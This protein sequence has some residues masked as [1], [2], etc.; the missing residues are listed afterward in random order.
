M[1]SSQEIEASLW[2]D[3][4]DPW[5][6]RCVNPAGGFYQEF[7]A[8]WTRQ[9]GTDRTVVFQS[10]MTWVTATAS[11]LGGT[12]DQ[13]FAGYAAHGV[14]SLVDRFQNPT[15]GAIYWQEGQT[16]E[17]HAYGVSFAIYALAAAARA[18]GSAEA[19]DAAIRAFHWLELHHYDPENGGYYEA[20]TASGMVITESDQDRDDLG[21]PYGQKSQNT[22]LH[23]LEAFTE[24]YREW[25]DPQLKIRLTELLELFMGALYVAPGW[26]YQFTLPDWTPVPLPQGD[27][28]FGH[29]VEAAHLMLD[30][31]DAL[32]KRDDP[33]VM[34]AA[35]SLVDYALQFGFKDGLLYAA[36]AD[37][38][39]SEDPASKNWW[40]QAESLLALATLWNRTGEDRYADAFQYQWAWIRDH[41]I[42]PIHRGWLEDSAEPG[43]AK[44]H[45]WKAAYHDGRA[46]IFTARRLREMGL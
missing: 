4:L 19:L 43:R 28:S 20:T 33:R 36:P 16:E 9:P 23:L 24:L 39:C 25:P 13:E 6:P 38:P 34:E 41:Q 1:V 44:G 5:F 2:Q 31:A 29:D 37:Q 7:A 12:R 40:A 45:R 27:V 22:H 17:I 26:L 21:T 35:R 15:S 3:I 14:R 32:G 10:R 30:A 8:D 11:E 46:M 18:L 42:D